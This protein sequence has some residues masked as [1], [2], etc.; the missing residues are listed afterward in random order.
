MRLELTYLVRGEDGRVVTPLHDFEAPW[1]EGA[2]AADTRE[3]RGV[4]ARVVSRAALTS[5]KSSPRDDPDDAAK[6]SA[7]F[8]VLSGL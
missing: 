6:D 5:G 4:H 2:F 3:L 1:P 7:D 8:D